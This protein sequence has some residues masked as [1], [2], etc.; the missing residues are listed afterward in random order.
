MKKQNYFCQT[1]INN[2]EN[3]SKKRNKKRPIINFQNNNY[4]V[5]PFRFFPMNFFPFLELGS[6]SCLEKLEN[7]L[8]SSIFWKLR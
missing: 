6:D 5:S 7:K 3:N 8:S 2:W 4:L 1:D